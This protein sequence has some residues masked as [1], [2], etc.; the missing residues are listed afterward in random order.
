MKHVT[1]LIAILL[2]TGCEKRYE[3]PESP[4]V[5]GGG[6]EQHGKQLIQ[7]YGCQSCHTI[8]GVQGPKGVVGPPLQKMAMR[9]YIAGKVPNTPANMIQW[10]QNPQTIDPGNAMPNLGVTASDAKDITA[11]LFTLK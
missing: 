7:Q 5:T 4:Q 6:D 8:P 2:L 1:I 9:G 10:L 11:Y 3:K